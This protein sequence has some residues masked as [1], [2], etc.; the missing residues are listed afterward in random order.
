MKPLS[1]TTLAR[2]ACGMVA[3]LGLTLEADAGIYY[4]NGATGNDAWNGT[5]PIPGFPNGPNIS[6]VAGLILHSAARC[7][8]FLD[9]ERP[10]GFLKCWAHSG[11]NSDGWPRGQ[12]RRSDL[13]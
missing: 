9:A 2:F 13:K 10:T 5:S 4:V 12:A 11:R 3:A 8:V 1:Q 6:S 7:G